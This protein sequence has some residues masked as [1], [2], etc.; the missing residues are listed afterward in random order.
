[1]DRVRAR[2]SRGR[3]SSDETLYDALERRTL[4][5]DQPLFS[6]RFLR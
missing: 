1:M 5:T 3:F 6:D 2:F 4:N